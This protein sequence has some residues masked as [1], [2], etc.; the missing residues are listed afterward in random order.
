MSNIVQPY[1][2]DRLNYLGTRM[3][4]LDLINIVYFPF[5]P[6]KSVPD[7]IQAGG[8]AL[9]AQVG[10]SQHDMIMESGSMMTSLT[11][12]F[13]IF[14]A[15]LRAVVEG[16]ISGQPYLPQE[17]DIILD[18]GYDTFYCRVASINSQP[19]FKFTNETNV[20]MRVRTSVVA[21][22]TPAIWFPVPDIMATWL[23]A[24]AQPN[25]VPHYIE[26]TTLP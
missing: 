25:S 2:K 17:G 18:A 7:R 13:F 16:R 21:Q 8:I 1:F 26:D 5:D 4:E 24:D 19:T 3:E 12:D 9:T 6:D 23:R 10:R 11:R 20:R 15:H 14:S 22:K